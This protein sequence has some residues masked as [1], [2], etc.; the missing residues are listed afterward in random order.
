MGKY[1][2]IGEYLKNSTKKT[3]RLTFKKIEEILGFKLPKSFYEHRSNWANIGRPPGSAWVDAGWQVD[4]VKLGKSITFKKVADKTPKKKAK[5]A[6]SVKKKSARGKKTKQKK[7][8]KVPA[9]PP[10]K[11]M[12]KPEPITEYIPKL[13]KDLHELKLY[14]VI[15]DNE[16]QQKKSELLK[17]V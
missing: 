7:T 13:I 14:G 4:G 9:K 2:P 17:R 10:E 12:V 6:A 11:P 16:F 8:L 1:D 15:T 5:P 3:E